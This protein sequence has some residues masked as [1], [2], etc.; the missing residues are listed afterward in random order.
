MNVRFTCCCFDS[1]EWNAALWEWAQRERGEVC[2]VAQQFIF[3]LHRSGFWN[4]KKKSRCSYVC[5]YIY[6]YFSPVPFICIEEEMKSNLSDLF[7]GTIGYFSS[8]PRF[9]T[10]FCLEILLMYPSSSTGVAETEE[11]ML[12]CSA[13]GIC[14]K[15][16][17]KKPY[18]GT[19][20]A[21][22]IW[23][24][25]KQITPWEAVKFRACID[26][27]HSIPKPWLG[28]SIQNHHYFQCSPNWASDSR[29]MQS[30]HLS[31]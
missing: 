22:L 20:L 17:P 5:V 24:T 19:F 16:R 2:V 30:C 10:A 1:R 11:R 29:A 3:L 12:G 21:L 28:P 18:V 9:A 25:S 14:C 4:R 31:H 15:T 26:E 27:F 6:A 8:F 13:A 7:S 23:K